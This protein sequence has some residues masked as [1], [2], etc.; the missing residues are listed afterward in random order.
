MR[1]NNNAPFLIFNI[2]L[3]IIILA[4]GTIY[5]V[6]PSKSLSHVPSYRFDHGDTETLAL[7][8]EISRHQYYEIEHL[9]IVTPRGNYHL[10][11]SSWAGHQDGDMRMAN[12][13]QCSR[14]A[15]RIQVEVTQLGELDAGHYQVDGHGSIETIKQGTAPIASFALEHAL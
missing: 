14:S 13:S 11:K 9:L 3:L 2:A 7:Q 4:V 1:Y 5:G 12:R 6:S 10:E 8:K 15:C